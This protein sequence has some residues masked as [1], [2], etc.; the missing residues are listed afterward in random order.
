HHVD[1][2]GLFLNGDFHPCGLLDRFF[3]D[4]PS[5]Y[6][7]WRYQP[8]SLAR[9]QEDDVYKLVVK[10]ARAIGIEVGPVKADVLRTSEGPVLLE[11]APR[12]HGDVSTAF[13]SPLATGT[14]P[15]Q[16][17]L[18]YLAGTAEPRS[19]IPR[20]AFRYAGWMGI[21]PTAHGRL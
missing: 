9:S 1:V 12:F 3:S 21:F 18:A 14:S 16:A 10:A 15:I 19:L 4:R 11:V 17:W 6:P 7:I 5:H 8:S 13:V 20:E 2:N